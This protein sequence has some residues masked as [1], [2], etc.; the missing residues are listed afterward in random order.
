MRANAAGMFAVV[1]G[2]LLLATGL[3]AV[4]AVVAA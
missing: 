4:Y 2:A 1:I 3:R